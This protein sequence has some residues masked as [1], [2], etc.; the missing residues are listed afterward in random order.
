MASSVALVAKELGRVGLDRVLPDSRTLPDRGPAITTACLERVTAQ[1]PGSIRSVRVLDEHHGTAGRV[2]LAIDTAPDVDL[3]DTLFVKLTPRNVIQRMMMSAFA[4]G[5]REVLFY[6]SIAGD[7]PVRTPRCYGAEL[8]AR[9]GRNLMVLED[10]SDTATFRDIREPASAEEAAAVIDALG[11]LHASFWASPR[12]GG[13]LAPLRS[14]SAA[15]EQLGNVFVGRVLGNLKGRS[16]DAVPLDMQRQSRIVFEQKEGIDAFWAD[17]PQTLLHGDTHFGNLFFEAGAPGFLDWQATMIGPSIRDVSYFLGASVDPTVLEPIERGLVDHY[18]H[19]LA[20]HGVDT[21][22][23]RMWD[24]YRASAADFYVAAVVTAGTADRMQPPEISQTGVDRT[25]AAMQRLG[26]FDLLER[27]V[28][29][30]K[31]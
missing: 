11:D 30:D 14:R 27:I 1:A 29:G 17:E 23:E 9:R 19:R 26:T 25:V 2:R 24:L 4:L 28:A 18:V 31:I 5:S 10:L 6:S 7:A 13:D 3:P 8:D 12:L 15:A 21:D 22:P 16:A 20:S